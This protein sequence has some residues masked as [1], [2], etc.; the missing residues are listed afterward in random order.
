MSNQTWLFDQRIPNDTAV[1]RDLLDQ[2]VE[3][4]KLAESSEHDVHGVHLSV[5]E[6]LVNA[7]KHGNNERDDT[8]V[9]VVFEVSPSEIRVEI[10]DQGEGFDPHEVPDPTLDENLAVPSGRGLMLMKA[11]MSVVRYNEKGNQVIMEKLKN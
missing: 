8:S 6:A 3:Q 2:L 10:T 1:G 9:H 4:L 11:F 5:E 7:I